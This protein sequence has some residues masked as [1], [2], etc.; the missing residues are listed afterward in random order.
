MESSSVWYNI[1][2]YL[3]E[4]RSFDVVLSNP[5]KTRA[6]ASAKI[7]TDKLDA[8]KLADLLRGGYIAEC[9]V[10][11]NKIMELRELVRHRIVLVRMKTKLKNSIHGIMLMKGIQVS[12]ACT[13]TFTLEY[14]D[15][16]KKLNDYRINHYISLIESLDQE[17]KDVSKKII[18]LAKENKMAK[19]L[20]TIP[21]IGHYSALFLV[22]EIDD[23]NSGSEN[24]R[25]SVLFFIIVMDSGSL[26]RS[27]AR[28]LTIAWLHII[29]PTHLCLVYGREIVGP[30]SMTTH[31]CT[32]KENEMKK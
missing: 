7:K 20:T 14:I 13:H 9:Y 2:R 29:R 30:G 18:L 15:E 12:N 24:L 27:C 3:S 32:K 4:E 5:V 10:P 11:N 6:I 16:L 23:I 17:I 21:G 28:A 26:K 8:V 31:Y 25:L 22:S 1:Y 19:L